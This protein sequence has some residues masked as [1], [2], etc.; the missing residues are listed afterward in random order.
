MTVDHITPLLESEH[1]SRLFCQ[2]ASALALGNSRGEFVRIQLG[3]FIVLRKLDGGVRGIIVGEII[4]QA[5][6][7]V[8]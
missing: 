7:Q 8:N 2:A 3:R 4:R 1:D 5:D 6:G